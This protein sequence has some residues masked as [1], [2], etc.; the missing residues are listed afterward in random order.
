MN[1]N[2]PV[3]HGIGW[4]CERHPDR[5]YDDEKGCACGYG[6]PCACNDSSPPDTSRM[7][8]LLEA[9]LHLSSEH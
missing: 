3:C 7:N 2:C 8:A 5:P 9:S 4:V 1:E 6:A